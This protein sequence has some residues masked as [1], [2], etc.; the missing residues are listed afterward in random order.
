MSD[1][2]SFASE[3]AKITV[4]EWSAIKGRLYRIECHFAGV[5]KE[6]RIREL[7]DEVKALRKRIV[8]AGGGCDE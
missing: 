7:M 8:S 1:R 3:P 6:A 5:K 2:G 4:G